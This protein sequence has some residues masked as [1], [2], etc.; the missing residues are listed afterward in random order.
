MKKALH[1]RANSIQA[2]PTPVTAISLSSTGGYLGRVPAQCPS[3]GH[4]EG[5]VYRVKYLK[6]LQRQMYGRAKLDLLCI[7]VLHPN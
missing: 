3:S 6:Y 4:T 7:R 1:R 5:Q 2:V